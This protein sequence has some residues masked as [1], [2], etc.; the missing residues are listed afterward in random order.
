MIEQRKLRRPGLFYFGMGFLVPA[1]ITLVGYGING[2]WPFGDHTVLIIDSIHQYLPF[3]T[4]LQQKLVHSESLLYSF[5]GGLGYDFW[6]T[7]AYYLASPLN[8]LLALFPKAHVADVMD[9]FILLK[10]ALCGGIFSWYLYKRAP[11]RRFWPIVFGTMFAL[12]NFMIGYSFNLMWLDSI[13]MVPLIMMGIEKIVAGK[14]GKM[15]GLALFYGLWCNYYIGFMLCIFSCLYLL[16]CFAAKR[17]LT[18]RKIWK[19]CLRF[20]WYSLLAGGMASVVLLP[21]YV[22]LSSSE[23]MLNNSFPSVI[24]FYT[25][26][27]DMVLAHFAGNAPV[28]ISSSQVGLNAYCGVA[29]L[30]LVVLYA[31]DDKIRLRERLAKLAL[32]GFLLLGFSMNILNYIW[33]GFHVQNGLPNRFAFL[34]ICLLL[35]MSFDVLE[36]AGNMKLWKLLV[37]GLLPIGF[38]LTAYLLKLGDLEPYVYLITLL[39]LLVYLLVLLSAKLM[40]GRRKLALYLAGGLM[41]A[42]A[43]G[44]GIY[45]L[46]CNGNV[47]RSSY[48]AD[49]ASFGTLTGG[50]EDE[51]FYRSEI[52]SQR[53]RNVTMYAGGHALV[54]FNS[55]MPASTTELCDRLGIEARTNKN[56]YNGVTKLMNDVFGI[57]YVLSSKGKGDSIYQFEKVDSD[58]NLT[59]YENK[60]A[61]SLGFMVNSSIKEWNIY[62]DNPMDV[63]NSFVQLATGLEP[64]FLFDRQIE[65]SNGENYGILIPENKQ[66]YLYLANRVDKLELN[67]P[68]YSKTYDTYTDHLY[69]INRMDGKDMADFT[70][71]MDEEGVQTARV[72][73]CDNAAYQKVVDQLSRNQLEQVEAEGNHLSGTI[74]VDQEGTM[75]LTVPYSENWS[76]TVDG[77]KAELIKIGDSLMGVDLSSGDHEI[78]MTYTPGGLWLG[79]IL[80][81]FCGLLFVL[82]CILEK[83]EKK[84]DK[85]M[86]VEFSKRATSFDAGIFAVLNERKEELLKEGK[87][88][89]NLSVGTPDFAPP[90]RVMEAVSRAALDPDNFKYAL[91]EL[92]QLI[93]TVQ[94]FYQKRF[95]VVLEKDEIM[96]IYGSQEGMA[97][98]AWVLC[99]PG[100]LVLVPNPGYPI[101]KIGPLF[102]DAKVWEY[103]LLKENDFLPDLKAI[104]SE[105]AEEARF[106]VVNYPGNPICRTAP[107]KFYR[108]LIDFAKKYDI[109]ILHDNAYSDIV[110][111]KREGEE[112]LFEPSLEDYKDC[113]GTSFLSFEGAKEVGIEFYSL[114][115][116]YNYTGARMSFVVGNREIVARFQA[117]R[118]QIDYGIFLPVQYGAIAALKTPEEEVLEQCRQYDLRNRTLCQGLRR[119][120]W[121]VPD[122]QGTMFVWAPLPEGYTNSE[123]FCME[124]M[125]RSGVICVPGSSFGNLGEGYVRFALVLPPK[126]LENVVESIER[127]GILK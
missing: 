122:S 13:A 110:F 120:G 78:S 6:A 23:S 124:L 116:S 58:D 97:H 16:V 37:S 65:M 77:A 29:V 26:F 127:S 95:G 71:T 104:P 44:H 83:R 36:H 30:V 118:S 11:G 55:T 76:L 48:M 3:Y 68:E 113:R 70:V 98:I 39:L 15:Y 7:F 45:G 86:K 92:P 40:K 73:V 102:C 105:V 33:H 80:S 9:Y 107:E 22:G 5:S 82:T 46:C 84:E 91:K 8:L 99:N 88:I 125:E 52:D 112:A 101:F 87:T 126:E 20:G 17:R 50:G 19:S 21:A 72:Y 66:V 75:L 60:N 12:S 31:L 51:E 35:V 32:A 85:K 53:M 2:I 109:V 4:E 27:F 61:L 123:Q 94:D 47:G 103:S 96:S 28:N 108:E 81:V 59:L 63:Q 69:V 56:G 14:G 115:K 34:Y 100:D 89:Y 24:K 1:L 90:A 121:Q 41:L 111:P 106:M 43:G 18:W 49:Q 64:I 117:L 25:S 57:R 93:E 62:Q 42:E 119:I 74:H 38:A 67:T 114:S 54:M 10:M 79:L